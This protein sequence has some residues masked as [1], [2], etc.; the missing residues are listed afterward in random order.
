MTA[1]DY[2]ATSER[3]TED[4]YQS[5]AGDYL[6]YLFHLATYDWAGQYAADARVLDFGTGTGYGA[7]RMASVAASVVGVDVSHAA[8]AYA[9]GR[10]SA[11]NLDFR[12]IA[13]VEEVPL[14]FADD[15][16]DVVTS[17]QVIEHV[18]SAAAY[19]AEARRVL[20]PGGKMLVVTP[21]RTTR[22]FPK[23]RPWNV[24][25]VHE[26]TPEELVGVVAEQFK[27]LETL[28][29]TAPADVV[30]LE[31]DRCRTLKVAAFPF[32]FPGAPE[33]WRRRGLGLLKKLNAAR[34]AR[35]APEERRDFGFAQGDI[36]ISASANPSVNILIVAGTR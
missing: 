26:Y 30:G 3:M 4:S 17:F 18:P 35:K 33:A 36:E 24:W 16:F 32:T 27:V 21:D 31:L 12:R 34:D 9:Q 20:K 25:H 28:G 29:M 11:G 23:Q 2:E 22:L 1:E 13:P 14:P 5:S 15:S 19:L 10:Y 7:A 8:I 6:I